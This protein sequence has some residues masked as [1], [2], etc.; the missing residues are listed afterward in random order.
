MKIFEIFPKVT[1]KPELPS[2]WDIPSN[3]LTGFSSITGWAFTGFWLRVM[4]SPESEELCIQYIQPLEDYDRKYHGELLPTLQEILQNGWNL[5]E[6]AAGPYIHYNS[7]KYRYSKICKVLN[8][9]LADH[10]NRSLV[11]IAMKLYL[12]KLKPESN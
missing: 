12:L 2:I 10:N 5:K 1:P 4:N 6:S 8:L 3:G 11:E 7:I 9:D